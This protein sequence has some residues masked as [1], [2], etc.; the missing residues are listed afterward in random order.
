[1]SQ[2]TCFLARD[3]DEESLLN[4]IDEALKTPSKKLQEKIDNAYLS[5]SKFTKEHTWNQ[6]RKSL[7][8][9]L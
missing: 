6:V 3:R 4:S 1:M 8:I 7:N 9:T 2:E 5:V